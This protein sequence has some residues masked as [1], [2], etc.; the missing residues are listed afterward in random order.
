VQSPYYGGY[1]AAST[2]AGG[3]HIVA[4]D[5]G[6]TNYASYLVYSGSKPIRAVLL[7]TDYYDGTGVRTNQTF[8]LQNIGTRVVTAMRLTA[9][10]A[11]SSQNAGVAPTF[12][13][14]S[15]VNETCLKTGAERVESAYVDKETAT[16]VL[17]ASEAL[18][19]N[20]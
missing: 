18:L 19:V 7:N 13:G 4:L 2:M 16:F 20:L 14:Q 10:A 17:Q 11:T 3:T 15:F 12:A 5:D 8:V 9:P 1:V 6:Q